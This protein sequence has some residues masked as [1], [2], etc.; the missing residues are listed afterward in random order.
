[1]PFAKFEAILPR[2]STI[3]YNRNG[4]QLNYGRSEKARGQRPVN[5]F[6]EI[7]RDGD[8]DAGHYPGIHLW[9]L[10]AR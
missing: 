4:E 1:M 7:L 6:P 10:Q 9:W 3:A 8:A 2:Y 5:A